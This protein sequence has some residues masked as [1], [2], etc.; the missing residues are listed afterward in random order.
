MLFRSEE[1][2]TSETENLF[3]QFSPTITRLESEQALQQALEEIKMAGNVALLPD[4][5]GSAMQGKIK[6][7]ALAT[8][9]DRAYYLPLLTPETGT[10]GGL[11]DAEEQ[12]ET[13]AVPLHTLRPLL[14]DPQIAKWGHLTKYLEMLLERGGIQPTPFTFDTELAGYVL[15]AGRP[16]YPLSDLTNDYLGIRLEETPSPTPEQLATQTALITLLVPTMQE[17]IKEL[18]MTDVMQ[19]IGRAHV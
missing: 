3:A 6:G 18:E 12:E 2:Q 16:S 15:S 19:Q 4:A 1:L 10:L 14:E 9:A 5:E 11:F 7:P 8:R 17:K 13:F